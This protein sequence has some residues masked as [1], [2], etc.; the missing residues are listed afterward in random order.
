MATCLNYSVRLYADEKQG[1]MKLKEQIESILKVNL[2][3]EGVV[4][5]VLADPF[6]SNMFNSVNKST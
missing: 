2:A 4:K 5:A 6:T 3:N 1:Y